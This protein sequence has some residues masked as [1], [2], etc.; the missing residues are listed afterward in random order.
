MRL[1][2]V[3]DR[4]PP[5]AET[6]RAAAFERLAR[7]LAGDHEVRLVCGYRRRR[8]LVPSD[9][10]AVDLS[11]V[12]P[13]AAQI[14]LWRTARSLARRMR[15]D[16]IVSSGA[17]ILPRSAP[18]VLVVRDLIGTGWEHRPA[19]VDRL[20]GRALR[21]YARVVVPTLATWRELRS[22][23]TPE[24]CLDRVPDA[25]DVVQGAAPAP[26]RTLVLVHPGRIHPA[27]GQHVTIDAVS[28]LAPDEKARV[29][30]HVVGRPGDARY[31][32]QLKVAARGQPIHFHVEDD[33]DIGAWLQRA[34]L[35]LV[36]TCV[37]E[38]FADAAVRAL[39]TARPVV[40]ADHPGVRES[41]GGIG[42]PV[43]PED[44]GAVRGAI[45]TALAEPEA[46]LALGRRGRAFVAAHYAWEVIGPRWEAVLTAAVRRR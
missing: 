37:T 32:G 2:L 28:R 4:F 16:V 33:A 6:G 20:L 44:A 10:L 7:G 25:V 9:A 40:F 42:F 21:R 26:S 39:A 22:R 15:P 43:P 45:R 12:G 3:A 27:K 23:G 36:P 30:L 18:A 8:S 5:D 41:V 17:W 38:G 14:A 34:H 35:V 13:V 46:L 31:L 11:G 19:A 29:E 1:L 24:W